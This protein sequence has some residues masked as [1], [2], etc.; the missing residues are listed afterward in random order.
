MTTFVVAVM[1]EVLVT[2]VVVKVAQVA[3]LLQP[4]VSGF[5]VTKVFVHSVVCGKAK[6]SSL[7]PD[8]SSILVVA[9][10]SLLSAVILM[11]VGSF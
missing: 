9:V 4:P 11:V 10:E 1:S 8:V 2:V 3:L 5:F 7:V 6:L